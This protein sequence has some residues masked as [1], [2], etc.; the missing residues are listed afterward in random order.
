MTFGNVSEKMDVKDSF[1]KSFTVS[2]D[3]CFGE[4]L[5][6]ILEIKREIYRYL[7]TDRNNSEHMIIDDGLSK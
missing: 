3:G 7:S 6:G 5:T 4:I 1:F 2:E